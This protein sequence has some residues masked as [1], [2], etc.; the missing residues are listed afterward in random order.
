M[1]VLLQRNAAPPAG[2]Q[3]GDVLTE[4]EGKKIEDV[5]AFAAIARASTVGDHVK[6]KIL[7]SGDVVDVN[8]FIGSSKRKLVPTLIRGLTNDAIEI[9]RLAVQGLS[10]LGPDSRESCEQLQE[11]RKDAPEKLAAAIDEALQRINAATVSSTS[12]GL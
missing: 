1:N 12:S 10:L 2:V 9:Q 4:F 11:L 7:R 3:L 5:D 8:L 6:L